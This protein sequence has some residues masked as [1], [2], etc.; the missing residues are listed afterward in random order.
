MAA[1]PAPVR[2]RW[3]PLVYYYLATVVGLT[4]LLV[5]LIGGLNGLVTAAFPS[6]SDE[7]IYSDVVN[8]DRQEKPIKESKAREEARAAEVQERARLR[9]FAN[10][11]RGG[12]TALVAA[13]VFFWHLRQ[14]RRKEP[15]WLGVQPPPVHTT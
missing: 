4:L 11:I 13:P 6:T 12:I 15:E 10:A 3:L 1:Q 14:A 5:G 2:G 7:Y 9:G 8:V